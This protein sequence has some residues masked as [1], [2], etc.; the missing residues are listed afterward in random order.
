MPTNNPYNNHCIL[1]NAEMHLKEKY[2]K[3]TY[4]CF[5]KKITLILSSNLSK[6][7]M[8][9]QAA[10]IILSNRPSKPLNLYILPLTSTTNRSRLGRRW[11]EPSCKYTNKY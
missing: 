1:E 8:T 5:M 3:L 10:S 2:M 6:A 4:I 11:G 9:R 7:S